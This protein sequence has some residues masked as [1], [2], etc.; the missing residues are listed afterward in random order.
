M[1][2]IRAP[3]LCRRRGASS[4]PPGLL[5]WAAVLLL[6]IHP[7]QPDHS[8]ALSAVRALALLLSTNSGLARPLCGLVALQI[9]SSAPSR[10]QQAQPAVSLP[11]GIPSV[12]QDP[13]TLI[14]AASPT[15]ENAAALAV[16]CSE[17]L[18]AAAHGLYCT[19]SL[20]V[21]IVPGHIRPNASGGSLPAPDSVQHRV[22]QHFAPFAEPVTWHIIERLRGRGDSGGEGACGEHIGGIGDNT[23]SSG[24]SGSCADCSVDVGTLAELAAVA[25]LLQSAADALDAL[26]VADE[27]SYASGSI[28][29][30]GGAVQ[31]TCESVGDSV[32][33]P[34]GDNGGDSMSTAASAEKATVMLRHAS[35]IAA[36]VMRWQD[37]ATRPAAHH[38]VGTLVL[39]Q[40]ADAA[41]TAAHALLVLRSHATYAAAQLGQPNP[42]TPKTNRDFLTGQ[43]P[44]WCDTGACVRQEADQ[45]SFDDLTRQEVIDV[46]TA[47]KVVTSAIRRLMSVPGA[48][49][50]DTARF[51]LDRLAESGALQAATAKLSSQACPPSSDAIGEGSSGSD[52]SNL[53]PSDLLKGL[54]QELAAAVQ[55]VG[56]SSSSKQPPLSDQRAN[57]SRQDKQRAAHVCRPGVSETSLAPCAALHV[58][59]S[60][61]A[62]FHAAVQTGGDWWHSEEQLS[63]HLCVP[64]GIILWLRTVLPDIDR[65]RP[66]AQLVL[67]IP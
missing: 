67:C 4:T 25:L 3:R 17:L 29:D 18:F 15:D 58:L 43:S 55:L 19:S 54:L 13:A 37:A 42:G 10:L 52:L 24:G 35:G 16:I 2:Q 36:A 40:L 20:A 5:D 45:R 44:S 12:P 31:G 62:A 21:E 59:Q 32:V 53:G 46:I 63:P 50:Y 66:V 65:V 56:G 22:L 14:G 41:A 28:C 48:G 8:L 6:L 7:Q 49:S 1:A 60:L 38:L 39:P 57:L 27:L 33:H 9:L 26:A 64:V 34:F 47:A 23:T 51:A 11:E 61:L 30:G